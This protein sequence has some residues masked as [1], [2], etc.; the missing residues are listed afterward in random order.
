[1]MPLSAVICQ[2]R[3]T[4]S[5]K[6]Y[7][8]ALNRMGTEMSDSGFWMAHS[9]IDNSRLRGR[10]SATDAHLGVFPRRI[11]W[12][13]ASGY[14]QICLW[15][16]LLRHIFSAAYSGMAHQPK[17]RSASENSASENSAP[18]AAPVKLP[19]NQFPEGKAGKQVFRGIE[20]AIAGRESEFSDLADRFAA[21]GGGNISAEVAA[22]LALDLVLNEIVEQACLSTAAGGAAVALRRGAEEEMVCRAT[23]GSNA[24]ELGSRLDT[25]AGLAG[26]CLRSGQIQCCHDAWTD[27]RADAAIS[28]AL[29][30]R[31]VVV[32]PLL[33]GS[34]LIGILEVFSSQKSAFGDRDLQ[35]LEILSAR[36]VRNVQAREASVAK[37]LAASAFAEEPLAGA[38]AGESLNA[39]EAALARSV[40]KKDRDGKYQDV[41]AGETSG[42][43]RFRWFTASAAVLIAVIAILMAA[44]FSMRMGWIRHLKVS[45]SPR[46]A[47]AGARSSSGN[48]IGNSSSPSIV[49]PASSPIASPPALSASERQRTASP[50][51]ELNRA[52]NGSGAEAEN[53]DGLVEKGKSDST[54]ILPSE[55]G[56]LLV[57]DRGKEIFRMQASP[58]AASEAENEKV[59]KL[60]PEEATE[61]L[62]YRVEPEYP[63]SALEQRIQGVVLL[64]VYIRRDGRVRE[65]RILQ[66]NALLADA[67][68]AAVKQWKF[69]PRVFRGS[70]AEAETTVTLKFMLPAN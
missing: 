20:V 45:R 55:P 17:V 60:T 30:V 10:D 23:S 21:H 57:Y 19:E 35:T 14:R 58:P 33:L 28:R 44:V 63:A 13:G 16:K 41:V 59:G 46:R 68:A 65:V 40:G 32:F 69:S 47:A 26:A 62:V 7:E 61:K 37:G 52:N 22:E 15:I 12:F 9:V 66:G 2:A 64:E 38:H 4:A 25:S 70:Y 6:T 43:R 36:V 5:G 24:P 18:S 67:A 27:P 49:T 34:K 51:P 3:M 11:E 42:L 54:F 53:T 29:G 48:L 1:M 39:A 31:S 50:T 56:S 8:D